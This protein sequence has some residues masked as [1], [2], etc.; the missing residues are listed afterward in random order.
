MGNLRIKL[1]YKSFEIELEGEE[2][3][4]QAEF[5]DIKQN[6]LGN[7]VTSVDLSESNYIIDATP[8]QIENVAFSNTETIAFSSPT[9]IPSLKDVIMRQLPSSE[10]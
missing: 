1:K 7:V 2:T 10:R 5:K 3:T 9:N 6:G 8:S 4:V